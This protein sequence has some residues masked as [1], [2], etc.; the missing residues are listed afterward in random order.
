M[1]GKKKQAHWGRVQLGLRHTGSTRVIRLITTSASSLLDEHLFLSLKEPCVFNIPGLLMPICEQY[2][3]QVSIF[4]AL[5]SLLGWC[6]NDTAVFEPF[7]L[8]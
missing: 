2:E 1:E 3:S 5:S 4:Q 8:L 6:F 7:L